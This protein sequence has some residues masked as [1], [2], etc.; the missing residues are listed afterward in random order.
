MGYFELIPDVW[1]NKTIKSFPYTDILILCGW[2]PV[3]ILTQ[4]FKDGPNISHN[5]MS[6]LLFKYESKNTNKIL[7]ACQ[8]HFTMTKK[9]CNLDMADECP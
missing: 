5:V 1:E 4:D 9:F 6:S 3:E 7:T 2:T 8:R